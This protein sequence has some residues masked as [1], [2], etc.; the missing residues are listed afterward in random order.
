M[1]ERDLWGRRRS[2]TAYLQLLSCLPV[3]VCELAVD[4]T[5]QFVN[6]SVTKITEYKPE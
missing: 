2:G 6:D 5:T 3:V 1:E 4:G